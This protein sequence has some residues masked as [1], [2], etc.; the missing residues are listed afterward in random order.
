EAFTNGST[1]ELSWVLNPRNLLGGVP[2]GV[3]GEHATDRRT[4]RKRRYDASARWDDHEWRGRRQ[5]P[6]ALNQAAGSRGPSTT[7]GRG[8]AR[9]PGEHGNQQRGR[10]RDQGPDRAGR[11]PPGR[12]RG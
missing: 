12:R 2:G 5:R 4:K 1:R 8:P 11:R 6:E 3:G 10:G 7:L 9:V